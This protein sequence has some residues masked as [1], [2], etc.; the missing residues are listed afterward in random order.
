M[1][2]QEN[3]RTL[4]ARARPRRMIFLALAV[5]YTVT[6]G[7]SSLA[8]PN[9]T[10]PYPM[11]YRHWTF[12]HS[13]MAPPTFGQF[14]KEPCQKPCTAGLFHFYGNEK[15]MEGL[16]TGSYPDG[17]IIAEEMLEFLGNE[18][19]GGKEGKRR[20]VGVMVKDSQRYSATGGWGFG[21][22]EDESKADR[23]DDKGRTTCFQCHVSQKDHG[24][25]FTEYRER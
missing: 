19:G 14:Q 7:L 20:M 18:N 1:T 17:A 9:D 25:V 21:I 11:G 24:Y 13:S 4:M 5:A 16:R 10:V 3:A 12:L 23:L 6:W 8:K 15:A 22:F 2:I